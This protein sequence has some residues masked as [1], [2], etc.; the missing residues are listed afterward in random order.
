MQGNAFFFWKGVD[1]VSGKAYIVSLDG[2]FSD[3]RR[4]EYLV[5]A[6]TYVTGEGKTAAG[7]EA[8]HT[9]RSRLKETPH[10]ESIE[11]DDPGDFNQQCPWV[12]A[13]AD[14]A[15]RQKHEKESA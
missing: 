5:S 14:E 6:G 8:V 1:R 3:S 9:P 4:V 15:Q 10:Q 12:C 7:R 13:H 11:R 2:W